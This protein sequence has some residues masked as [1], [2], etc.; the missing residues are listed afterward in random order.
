MLFSFLDHDYHVKTDINRRDSAAT[1]SGTKAGSTREDLALCAACTAP[2]CRNQWFLSE[3][4]IKYVT[5]ATATRT[6]ASSKRSSATGTSVRPN[7]IIVAFTVAPVRH[8]ARNR[9]F[10]SVVVSLALAPALVKIARHAVL[11]THCVT[12]PVA[13]EIYEVLR[14]A[15]QARSDERRVMN[16]FLQV[17]PG[18]AGG[19]RGASNRNVSAFRRRARVFFRSM[20]IGLR[21]GRQVWHST[22]P[23][24]TMGKSR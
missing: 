5:C 8:G 23:F 9:I 1:I 11:H 18:P 4:N 22:R 2:P 16:E 24:T 10:I 6:P 12:F 13:P 21:P 19:F 17:H 20:D 3:E 7:F 15:V 14:S